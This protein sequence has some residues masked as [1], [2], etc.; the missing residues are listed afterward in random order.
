[1]KKSV[2]FAAIVLALLSALAVPAAFADIATITATPVAGLATATGPVTV[3]ATV[4]SKLVMQV[5]TSGAS[6]TVNF[7]DVDAGSMVTTGVAVVVWSNKAYTFSSATGGSASRMGLTTVAFP[8][9]LSKTNSSGRSFAD[10]YTLSVPWIT[11][12]GAYT[13][14]VTYTAVQN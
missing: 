8:P 10:T 1:M 14:T 13:S 11:D 3:S 2:V 9:S 7:G 5:T 12:P 4:D 6:Q